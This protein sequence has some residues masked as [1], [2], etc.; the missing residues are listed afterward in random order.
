MTTLWAAQ[1]NDLN[2]VKNRAKNI[3]SDMFPPSVVYNESENSIT[4]FFSGEEN[5]KTILLNET[6]TANKV[7]FKS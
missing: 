5:Y 7:I 6:A 2:I 1:K 3:L 4:Y